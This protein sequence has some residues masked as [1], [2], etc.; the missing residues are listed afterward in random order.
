MNYLTHEIQPLPPKQKPGRY[1]PDGDIANTRNPPAN[2]KRQS[3]A[4][5]FYGIPPLLVRRAIDSG[6]LETVFDA[7]NTRWIKWTDENRAKLRA[8]KRA[9]FS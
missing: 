5:K 8:I 1:S 3:E 6:R 4:A 2:V 7:Q 9:F